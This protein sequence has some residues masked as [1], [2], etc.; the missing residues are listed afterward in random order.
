M[1]FLHKT[2]PALNQNSLVKSILTAALGLLFSTTTLAQNPFPT[3]GFT[4]PN[5]KTIAISYEVT[6]NANACATAHGLK[7]KHYNQAIAPLL[8]KQRT[9]SKYP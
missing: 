9:E 8:H 7:V 5:G 1:N 6:V 4:L 2:S 3:S